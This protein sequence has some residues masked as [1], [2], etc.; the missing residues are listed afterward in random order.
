MWI[1][2]DTVALEGEVSILALLAD[3]IAILGETVG[4]IEV[5]VTCREQVV[6]AAAEAGFGSGIVQA[7][8]DDEGALLC[9]QSVSW[10]AGDAL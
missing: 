1:K 6:L 5:A 3:A 4:V 2:I 9:R 10:Q 7:A 8:R